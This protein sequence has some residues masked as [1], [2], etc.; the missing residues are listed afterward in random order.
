[1]AH[2]SPRLTASDWPVKPDPFWSA[3]LAGRPLFEAV[4][5]AV[6]DAE[7]GELEHCP[8]E[9]DPSACAAYAARP[10]TPP[11]LDA[12][13]VCPLHGDSPRYCGC[14]PC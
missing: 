8:A 2:T 14:D 7:T 13:G 6:F 9:L 5:C 12:L 11:A 1:M 3:A 10:I 4:G